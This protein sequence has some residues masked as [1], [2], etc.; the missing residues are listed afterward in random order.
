MYLGL[1]GH[2]ST[3]NMSISST[4]KLQLKIEEMQ[5]E[6]KKLSDSTQK[7]LVY[8]Q[9]FMNELEARIDKITPVNATKTNAPPGSLPDVIRKQE[10]L[11]N[12]IRELTRTTNKLKLETTDPRKE[13]LRKVE[14]NEKTIGVLG[15]KREKMQ[16]QIESTIQKLEALEHQVDG[17][18]HSGDYGD[19]YSDGSRDDHGHHN[20]YS[21]RHGSTTP[22]SEDEVK[23][24]GEDFFQRD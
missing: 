12:Q 16:T 6:I 17:L 15:L 9:N 11:Q 4:G 10:N 19:D 18:S 23:E 5:S 21:R 20:Y 7:R 1:H 3:K 22:H 24:Y 8:I 2:T 13:L 14:V